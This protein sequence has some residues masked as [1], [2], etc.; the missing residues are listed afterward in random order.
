M[1]MMLLL[2]TTIF[3]IAVSLTARQVND[4]LDTEE[5]M[6]DLYSFSPYHNSFL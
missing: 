2:A 4:L 6:I 5:D 1:M 3:P